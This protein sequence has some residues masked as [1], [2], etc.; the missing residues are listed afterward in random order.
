MLID[1]VQFKFLIS[2]FSGYCIMVQLGIVPHINEIKVLCPG[3]GGLNVYWFRIS[4]SRLMG[5]NGNL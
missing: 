2:S 1:S 5:V 4:N 3:V